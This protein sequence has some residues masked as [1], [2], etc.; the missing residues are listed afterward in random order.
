MSKNIEKSLIKKFEKIS[1]EHLSI[2]TLTTRKSDS[3]DF[4]D[5]SVWG[6]VAAL[7]EAYELGKKEGNKK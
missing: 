7:N 6:V 2:E 3:L 1:R 5:V 4:Y